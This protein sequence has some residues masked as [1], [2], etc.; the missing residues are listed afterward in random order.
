MFVQNIQ[1]IQETRKMISREKVEKN[2][3]DFPKLSEIS[4]KLSNNL[5]KTNLICNL[6]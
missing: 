5:L 4:H 2:F 3:K 1:Y 6:P